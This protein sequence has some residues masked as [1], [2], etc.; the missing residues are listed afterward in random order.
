M[1]VRTC[2]VVLVVLDFHFRRGKFI[3]WI[4]FPLL[5][6]VKRCARQVL[7]NTP[8][9]L[10]PTLEPHG[11][12]ALA[13]SPTAEVAGNREKAFFLEKQRIATNCEFRH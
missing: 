3:V 12:F 2:R 1:Y 11:L 7:L 13:H 4:R 5:P 10:L 8:G 6:G 9:R